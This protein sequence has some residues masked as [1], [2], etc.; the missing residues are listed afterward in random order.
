VDCSS[1]EVGFVGLGLSEPPNRTVDSSAKTYEMANHNSNCGWLLLSYKG[2][3][4]ASAQRIR[5]S[6]KEVFE[7][8]H[9]GMAEEDSWAHQPEYL[10]AN[11]QGAA[12]D[13]NAPALGYTLERMWYDM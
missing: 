6:G 4:I 3:F 2:Q 1:Q 10:G 7:Y 8:L 5:G 11:N 12:D 9:R 13:M